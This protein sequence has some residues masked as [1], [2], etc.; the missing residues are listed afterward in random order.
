MF[1]FDSLNAFID[2]AG[3][4]A[5]VWVSYGVSLAI[6]IYLVVKPVARINQQ[7]HTLKRQ[8]GRNIRGTVEN[9]PGDNSA[10]ADV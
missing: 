6:M 8:R 4:G 5:Y 7:L 2:M 10:A 1:Q 3:H 9:S